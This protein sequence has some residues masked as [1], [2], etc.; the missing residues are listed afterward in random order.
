MTSGPGAFVLGAVATF[1][2]TPLAIR[3]ARRTGCLD[4]PTGHKKHDQA[5]PYFGGAAVLGGF[6]LATL[7]LSGASARFSALLICAAGLWLLGT[8]DDLVTVAPRWRLL[9]ELG[10][11][12]ILFESGL[13]WKILSSDL[14]NV[15]LTAAWTVGLVNAFNLMDNLDGA[16]SSVVAGSCAGIAA[17]ALAVGDSGLAATA[18]AMAGACLAFLRYNL[19]R[20]ARIFLGD[21]GSMPMGLIVSSL[22][23]AA[24]DGQHLHGAAL[25][26]GGLLVGL[27]ILDTALVSF[28]RRRRGVSLLQGGRDHL[29]HRLLSRFG[30]PQRVALVLVT[31][32]LVLSSI[33][34]VA[35][36]VGYYAVVVASSVAVVL[37]TLAIAVL[38]GPRWRPA[39]S[40]SGECKQ[41]TVDSA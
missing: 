34:V 40:P 23:I 33:V 39:F 5:T 26:A 35:S 29:T 12:V 14:S 20:P 4:R 38:D 16:S 30:S 37:G 22:A 41:G 15:L 36:S 17:L 1:A 31:L 13:G 27:A 6:T 21:G 2:L 32:Q 18:L 3:L 8:L 10:A 24:V 7:T 9:A 19:A 11:A 25:L 28:S